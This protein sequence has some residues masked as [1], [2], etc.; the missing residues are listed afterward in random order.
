MI[1]SRIQFEFDV[2]Y[3]GHTTAV[4]VFRRIYSNRE[5]FCKALATDFVSSPKQNAYFNWIC[6]LWDSHWFRVADQPIVFL[7]VFFDK[8]NM[9]LG[10]GSEAWGAWHGK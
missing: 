5:K 1:A 7:Q 9:V 2:Q 3:T 6:A 10:W 4:K 8:K